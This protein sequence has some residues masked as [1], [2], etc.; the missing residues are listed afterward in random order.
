MSCIVLI[1][2]RLLHNSNEKP[3][4]FA[5][6]AMT[7]VQDFEPHPLEHC[8][9]FK[10]NG[11]END[12]LSPIRSLIQASFGPVREDERFNRLSETS[13]LQMRWD[14][15]MCNELGLPEGYAHVSVLLIKWRREIDQL[16]TEKE[17]ASLETLFKE[18][19]GFQTKVF[20]LSESCTCSHVTCSCTP[21]QRLD[22]RIS[23]F[24][25]KWD[26]PH[27]LSIIY[28]TGHGTHHDNPKPGYLKLHP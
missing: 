9:S 17:V 18:S 16:K 10:T 24:L 5:L 13:R 25:R 15:A 12:P 3:S 1:L 27:T 21:Q 19:L 6:R 2:S 14:Q 28:Y 8:S 20:D 7:D 26:S 22:R 11:S 4:L 23:T